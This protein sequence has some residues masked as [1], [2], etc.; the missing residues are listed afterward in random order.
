M[1]N[2]QEIS[3]SVTDFN[4]ELLEML[5]Q[6]NTSEEE[7]NICF[8]CHRTQHRYLNETFH[9]GDLKSIYV[10]TFCHHTREDIRRQRKFKSFDTDATDDDLMLCK[11]C[12]NHLTKEDKETYNNI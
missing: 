6:E 5:Y 1:Q 12:S 4:K 9:S 8:N 10:M 3:I 11:E 7:E 2:T